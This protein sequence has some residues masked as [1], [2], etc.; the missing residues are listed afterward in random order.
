MKARYAVLAVLVAALT[1]TS[2]A[3]AGPNVTK[4]RVA[5]TATG[6]NFPIGAGEWELTPLQAGALES[7]SGTE[8]ATYKIRVVRRGGLSV[9][10]SEW[11]TPMKGKRGT[12]VIRLLE[13]QVPVG[14]G[15]TVFIG[16]WK[17]LRGT[18]QYA[19]LTGGGRELG[20]ISEQGWNN[21]REGVLTVG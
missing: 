12:L 20:V 7:D 11:T 4:Q 14:N 21:R 2:V 10:L 15:Y 6:P 16:T 17:V 1:L 13:E 8:T 5:I 18:G 9:R 3:A 19:N